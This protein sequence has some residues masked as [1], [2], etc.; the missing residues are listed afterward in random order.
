MF[1]RGTGADGRPPD[2]Q[3][4]FQTPAQ[5]PPAMPSAAPLVPQPVTMQQAFAPETTGGRE[6]I[7]GSDLVILGDKIT[8]IT[9]TR[10]VVDGE[11]R[12]DINGRE[13]I[14][15]PTGRVTGTV[16]ANAIEVH[17]HVKGA[18]KA[19]SVT[20]HPTAHVDGDIHNQVLK[21]SEGAVFDGR[22]RRAKDAAELAPVLDPSAFT[23][24]TPA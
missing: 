12:G 10:L 2:L 23:P 5:T 14:I 21:I 16:A 4:L 7:I 17:G 20:L 9:K 13:V 18:V 24:K 1:N 6:S 3:N 19:A 8:V 15:G 22:V 11:V